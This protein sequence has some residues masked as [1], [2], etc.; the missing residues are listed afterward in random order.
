MSQ[1][2]LK[3]RRSVEK[4][5]VT[6]VVEDVLAKRYYMQAEYDG[7]Q[8]FLPTQDKKKIIDTLMDIDIAYL[9]IY[10]TA[11]KAIDNTSS[12]AYVLFVFGND[13]GETVI[14]D[15]STNLEDIG[16]LTRANTISNEIQEGNFSITA[17]F[18]KKV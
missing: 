12:D 7:E 13:T 2:E 10:F 14:S 9:N 17:I 5:I 3:F 1:L 4:Q 15:Y 18:K 16:I 11:T 6:A 8:F